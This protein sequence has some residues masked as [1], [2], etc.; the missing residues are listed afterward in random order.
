MPKAYDYDLRC[1]VLEA[2]ELNG[3]RRCEASEV[4]GISRNTINLWFQLKAKTGD[5][6][7]RPVGQGRHGQKIVDWDKFREFVSANPDKTQAELAVLWQG[8][9]SKRTIGRALQHIGFTRK[10]RLMPIAS[11]MSK[12]E[13][14]FVSS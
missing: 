1:K 8:D 7:P 5:V 14:T 6:K 9:I 3:M 12:S 2:I 11:E 4:F 10:K 13:Q